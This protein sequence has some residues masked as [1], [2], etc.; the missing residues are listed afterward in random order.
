MNA[1]IPPPWQPGWRATAVLRQ[2]ALFG[3]LAVVAGVLLARLPLL[4]GAALVG[5]TAVILLTCIQPLVG[6][7]LMLLLGPF[8]ALESVLFGW[9]LDSGQALLLL[10]LAVWLARGLSRRRLML[11]HTFLTVPLGLF[12]LV[13]AATVLDA[14]AVTVGLRELMKWVEIGLLALLV[15]DFGQELDQEEGQQKGGNGRIAPWLLVGLLLF[16]GVVQAAI[17]IW[18][19]GLRG[20]G[21]E[22][23]LVLGRFYRASGT[24]EQ[25]NPFGGFINLSLLL[26]AGII[27]SLIAVL[28]RRWREREPGFSLTAVSVWLPLLLVGGVTLLTGLA[29]VFSWSRGA[30]LGF[31]AGTAVLLFFWPRQR[32]WGVAML[33]VGALFF[34]IGLQ[35]NLIPAGVTDRLVS[36]GADLQFGDVRGADINDA[37]YAVLERLAHWQA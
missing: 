7:G 14:P 13:M 28:W 3:A 33:V 30:W 34:I 37:N 16:S 24:F 27:L 25:P 5:G 19:F 31:V 11:P 9:G 8:G 12:L 17:G 35:A 36:F 29:L 26:A 1:L 20:D 32:R 6:L 15:V 4:W 18:Q 22:H 2:S 23:F 10:V 21:P